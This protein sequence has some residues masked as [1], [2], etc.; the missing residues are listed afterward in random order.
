MN[1][2]FARWNEPDFSEVVTSLDDVIEEEEE[3]AERKLAELRARDR[4]RK[5]VQRE[6]RKAAQSAA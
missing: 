6:A 2:D 5:R 3:T 4:E 1:L